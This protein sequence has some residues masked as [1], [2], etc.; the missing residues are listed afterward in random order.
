L[1]WAKSDI[2]I[3]ETSITPM[4]NIDLEITSPKLDQELRAAVQTLLPIRENRHA[5]T[6]SQ[7]R[8]ARSE[9]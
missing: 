4:P 5:Q 1:A 6:A 2:I 9:N 7:A 8:S 3:K